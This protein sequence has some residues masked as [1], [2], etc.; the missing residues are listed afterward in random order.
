MVKQ[1]AMP[2]ILI[3]VCK[4]CTN[5]QYCTQIDIIQLYRIVYNVAYLRNNA[6]IIMQIMHFILITDLHKLCTNRQYCTQIDII[7]LYRIVYNVAYLRNNA[8]IIMQVM[9]FILITDLHGII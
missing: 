5:R 9:H 3:S 1:C 2:F 4:L 8:C 6:C 7:Q